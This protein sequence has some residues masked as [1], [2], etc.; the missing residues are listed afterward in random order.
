MVNE[1]QSGP[2][3]VMEISH[4]NKDANIVATF[5]NLCGPMDPVSIILYVLF[6]IINIL[7]QYRILR[8]KLDQIRLERSMEKQKYRMVYIVLTCPKTAY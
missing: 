4:E 2:C 6:N 8:G 5:R 1:L 3:I 7:I